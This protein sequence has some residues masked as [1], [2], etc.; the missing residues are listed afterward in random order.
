[1]ENS[2][3]V[4]AFDDH[5]RAITDGFIEV[6]FAGAV[7]KDMDAMFRRTGEIPASTPRPCPI[8]NPELDLRSHHCPPPPGNGGWRLSELTVKMACRWVGEWGRA[9]NTRGR[10]PCV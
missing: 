3:K 4:Q 8:C 2:A 1:M 9:C 6:A 7:R 5:L 10:Q